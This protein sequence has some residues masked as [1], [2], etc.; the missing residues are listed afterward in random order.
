MRGFGSNSPFCFAVRVT[1]ESVILD[2]NVHIEDIRC[3]CSCDELVNMLETGESSNC[4]QDDVFKSLMRREWLRSKFSD[5]LRDLRRSTLPG[6]S[7]NM[8]AVVLTDWPSDIAN[9]ER[10]VGQV[11]RLFLCINEIEAAPVLSRRRVRRTQKIDAPVTA[12]G[13]AFFRTQ[14][15][16]VAATCTH[17][18]KVISILS[19]EK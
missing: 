17:T 9:S 3:A 4:L 18:R 15:S 7:E 8:D 12:C 19:A 16:G 1:S 6:A 13:A 10:P 11:R 5:L 2:D 14:L